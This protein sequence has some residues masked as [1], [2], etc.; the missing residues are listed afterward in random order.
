MPHELTWGFNWN[1]NVD[2]GNVPTT[3]KNAII[4][5]KEAFTA[6]LENH[7]GTAGAFTSG[8]WTVVSSCDGVTADATD[9]WVD[10]SDI[11]FNTPGSAHSWIL[12]SK[13]GYPTAGVTTYVIIDC[14]DVSPWTDVSVIWS[15]AAPT[16]GTTTNCPTTNATYTYD[17]LLARY[18]CHYNGSNVT[19]AH[20]SRSEDGDVFFSTWRQGYAYPWYALITAKLDTPRSEGVD[21]W[22]MWLVHSEHFGGVGALDMRLGAYAVSYYLNTKAFWSSGIKSGTYGFYTYP[23]GLRSYSGWLGDMFDINGDDLDGT[24]PRMPLF[25][26]SSYPGYKSLRG[27][28]RDFWDGPSSTASPPALGT[29]T[30]NVGTPEFCLYGD[31]WVPCNQAPTV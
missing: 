11:V 13:A 3:T 24:Y 17:D 9:R 2:G 25:V 7:A 29:V 20:A 10:N 4:A 6:D 28:V 23:C 1:N 14:R 22:P 19:Y 21:P 15:T 16:G 5:L 26:A 31:I 12:L 8:K 18:L 30:P 27:R